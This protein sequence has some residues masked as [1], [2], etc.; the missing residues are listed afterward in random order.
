MEKFSAVDSE[1]LVDYQ[2]QTRAVFEK[3]LQAIVTATLWNWIADKFDRNERSAKFTIVPLSEQFFSALRGCQ[4]QFGKRCGSRFG[5]NIF[6]E[7]FGYFWLFHSTA[8]RWFSDG[9]ARF[10]CLHALPWWSSLILQPSTCTALSWPL[11]T[12]A[13]SR[14]NS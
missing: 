9:N 11:T 7:N 8:H 12:L 1:W 10:G 6:W 4:F 2:R 3:S 13:T 5:F 14:D